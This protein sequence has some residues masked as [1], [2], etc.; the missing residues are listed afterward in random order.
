M[1]ILRQ[2]TAVDVLIGPFLDLTDGATAETGESPSVYLSKNGQTLAVRNGTP[3][4]PTHDSAGYYNCELDAT[5]TGTVGTL[6]LIVAASANALPVRHEFQIVPGVTYDSLFNTA[7]TD[8][9]NVNVEQWDGANVPTPTNAG[10]PSVDVTHI[11]GTAAATAGSGYF[12][13]DLRMALGSAT[14]V[15]NFVDAFSGSGYN[16]PSCTMPTVTNVTNGV[17]VTTNNDK[18]GYSIADSTSD[19]VIADAVWNALTASYG[20]AG[21][22]GELVEGFSLTA[23]SIADAV[24]DEAQADHTGAGTFGEVA[25]EVASILDDTGTSGVIVATNNDKT[26]YSLSSSGLDLITAWTVNITGSLSGS[27]GSIS[28][29]TFPLNFEDLAITD[30]TG[31][32]SANVVQIEGSDPT[33]QIRDSVVDDATRIDASALNTLSGHDPGATIGTST[34]TQT[35]VTGGAYALDTDANGRIR[36]VD[37]TGVGELDTASGQVTVATNNDKTGYSL[38]ASGLTSITAW[39]VDITGSLSGAVGSVTGNVGGNLVGTIGGMTAAALADFFLDD[40]GTTYASAVSGSV[41]K[42]IADN[43]G[44]SSL[45]ESGIADAVWDELLSGHTIVGSAGKALSDA[46]AAGDPWAVDISSGYSGTQAGYILYHNLDAQVST[47]STFDSTTD[48]VDVGKWLGTACAT[49]TVA[50]VPEVDVT[51]WYGSA[52]SYVDTAGY[53]CVTIK[54]GTGQ[55]ELDITLGVVKANTVQ[56]ASQSTPATN[57][58]IVYNTDFAANYDTVN[59]RWLVDAVAISGDTTAANNAESAFDGTGYGFT[60]CTM[61][62]TTTVTNIVT[63]NTTQVEGSDATD[64]IQAACAAALTAYDA[65]VPGDFPANFSLLVIDV[66]GRVDVSLIEGL[67][68][69]DQINAQCDTALA[70]YDAVVPGDLPGNFGSLN[71]TASGNV[72]IDWATIENPTSIVDLANTSISLVDTCITNTDMRGTDNAALASVCTETRLSELDAANIPADVD[73]LLG[74]L[75]AA[76]AGYLDNLN[77]GENVAGVSDISG[78][79][80]IAVADI[81]AWSPSAPASAPT[82]ASTIGQFLAYHCAYDIHKYTQTATTWTLRNYTDTGNISTRAVSDDS[83]TFT[84]GAP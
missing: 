41:V 76:R 66:N 20:T 42:E 56:V 31:Y 51:H 21:T 37:G 60:N 74:R 58:N 24:W 4:T 9:L 73:T 30:T 59:D 50:G 80:D 10:Y 72:G 1:N 14:S 34:L 33:D 17:T 11:K 32:V 70:D 53:P 5:D 7:G 67:D 36:I 18:T 61:P 69:T 84:A 81:W 2:S 19:A 6:V 16:F 43:A 15:T 79:N 26:G 65:V 46:G 22:Y 44:G 23:G 8:Y 39:T 71:I 78:L 82:W 64:Q 52:I 63:A 49:P 35:Q 38:S 48:T 25:T 45:T 13:S 47:L 3:A 27:V 75:T 40:S 83:T 55:G 77:I 68:A 62:T 57:L 12:A 28:G 54:D 29:V